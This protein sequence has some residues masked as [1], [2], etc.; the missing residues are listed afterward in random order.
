MSTVLSIINAAAQNAGLIGVAQSLDSES[1]ADYLTRYNDMINLW[2]TQGLKLWTRQDLSITLIEGQGIYNLGVGQNV[3]MEKPMRV[4]ES[5]VLVTNGGTKRPVQ[6]ISWEEW[7]R[8]SQINQ[9]GQI[10]QIFVDHQKDYLGVNTWQLP[11]S[12]EV[13]NTLHLVIQGQV[14]NAVSLLDD[15]DFPVEW[16]MGLKWGLAD[17]ICTGQ[18]AAIVSRCQQRADMYRNALEAWDTEGVPI[19]FSPDPQGQYSGGKFR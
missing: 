5:Y 11:D 17:E 8:L 19:T 1:L 9:E 18:P 12:S 14:G 2:Q 3:P 4:C 15:V 7:S 10:N 13:Q 16:I 6:Q